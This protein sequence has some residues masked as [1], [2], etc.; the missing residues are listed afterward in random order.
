MTRGERMTEWLQEG[1]DAGFISAPFC[2]QHDMAPLSADELVEYEL[3]GDPCFHCVRL[4]GDNPEDS[5]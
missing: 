4:W 3:G 5:E 1:I 2:D